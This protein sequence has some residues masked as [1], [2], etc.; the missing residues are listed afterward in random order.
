MGRK[1]LRLRCAPDNYVAQRFYKRHGFKKIGE[2]PGSRVP[3]DI[4]EK[5]IGYEW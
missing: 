3:L 1:Y 5:Y 4:M 2:D